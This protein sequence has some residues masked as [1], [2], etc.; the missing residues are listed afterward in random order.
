MSNKDKF[1][2]Y[3]LKDLDYRLVVNRVAFEIERKRIESI[4]KKR[5]TV[6]MSNFMGFHLTD[7]VSKISMMLDS[8]ESAI[9]I[10]K[11]LRDIFIR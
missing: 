8:I 7:N 3:T 11:R 5:V 4:V 1:R 6:S 9:K 10:I 2:G